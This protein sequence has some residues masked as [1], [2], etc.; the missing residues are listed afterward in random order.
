MN[1]YSKTPFPVEADSAEFSF[2]SKDRLY[3]YELANRLQVFIQT[4][5]GCVFD[6]DYQTLEL[7]IAGYCSSVEFAETC[8]TAAALQRYLRKLR[9]KDYHY[10]NA[11][12]APLLELLQLLQ[13]K[14]LGFAFAE[15]VE[16][17]SECRALDQ[18]QDEETLYFYEDSLDLENSQV[19]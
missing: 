9:A 2:L 4:I 5:D 15:E 14:W 6:E 7:A 13:A 17:E 8:Y 19:A 1:A 3:C 12:S 10:V 11:M 18:W 16:A